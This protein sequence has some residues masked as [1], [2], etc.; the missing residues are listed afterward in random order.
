MT[1]QIYRSKIFLIQGQELFNVVGSKNG[2]SKI[3][4][5][6]CHRKKP[7]H[8]LAYNLF[9]WWLQRI[10]C[11]YWLFCKT[12][13]TDKRTFKKFAKHGRSI[14]HPIEMFWMVPEAIRTLHL[15][16]MKLYCYLSAALMI[17]TEGSAT[18]FLMASKKPIQLQYA[19][20]F[21]SCDGSYAGVTAHKLLYENMQVKR[22]LLCF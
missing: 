2:L 21:R 5:V 15:T 7:S 16:L 10:F 6:L 4:C 12:L 13:S 11:N 19:F 3:C 1:Q 22:S 20:N 9:F 14:A 17:C 8:S 18:L